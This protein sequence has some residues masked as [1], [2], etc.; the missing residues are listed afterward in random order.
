M[1]F[2]NDECLEQNFQSGCCIWA[3]TGLR[4]L[5]SIAP[6]KGCKL[7]NAYIISAFFQT[8]DVQRDRYVVLSS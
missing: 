4:I 1:R 8:G 6:I 2:S 5:L 3:P 7:L